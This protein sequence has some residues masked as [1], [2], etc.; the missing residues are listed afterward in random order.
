M[1]DDKIIKLSNCGRSTWGGYLKKVIRGNFR[2]RS[3]L[4][5]K[6]VNGVP[7]H[8]S[9]DHM[10]HQVPGEQPT[11]LKLHNQLGPKKGTTY[12]GGG[13]KYFIFSSLLG[14]RFPIWLIFF[15]WGNHQPVVYLTVWPMFFILHVLNHD[16]FGCFFG[17]R[18][19]KRMRKNEFLFP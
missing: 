2:M 5:F 19:R 10:W 1:K 4:Y 11:I 9:R 13:F 15:W 3:P 14:E 6:R 12:L 18:K 8:L 7:R 16:I 17:F